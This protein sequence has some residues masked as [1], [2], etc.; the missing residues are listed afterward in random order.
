MRYRRVDLTLRDNGGRRSGIERRKVSYFYHIPE[1]RSGMDRRCGQDRRSGRND[2]RASLPAS[3]D[4][5]IRQR[6]PLS[7]GGKD[8]LAQDDRTIA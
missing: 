6:S 1:R 8:L 5:S 2:H 7:Y 3:K 4:I